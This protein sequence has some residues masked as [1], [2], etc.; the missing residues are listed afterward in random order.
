MIGGGGI[1][2][3]SM[4]LGGF[5]I[6]DGDPKTPTELVTAAPQSELAA[7]EPEAAATEEPEPVVA[8]ESVVVDEPAATDDA[9]PVAAVEP[10]S[11]SWS[12]T[13]ANDV[14]NFNDG[15]AGSDPL[16]E[17]T[18]TTL[19]ETDGVRTVTIEVTGTNETI[20]VTAAEYDSI[21]YLVDVVFADGSYTT[22]VWERH[23]GT[24]LNGE[25]HDDPSAPRSTVTFTDR[26]VTFELPDTDMEITRVV[27]T[28]FSNQEMTPEEP[29]GPQLAD[30][31]ELAIT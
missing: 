23:L 21:A 19:T 12:T 25:N 10:T 1:L 3:M 2:G 28:A 27:V 4:V 30:H 5:V 24:E 18:K 11:Q 7:E 29:D 16:T 17:I 15:T 22:W 6:L 14:V 13:D 26:T 31:I 20:D 8:E 9:E